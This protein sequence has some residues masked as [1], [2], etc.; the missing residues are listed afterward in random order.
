[1]PASSFA[2]TWKLYVW[3]GASVTS[4]F[5]AV[6]GCPTST[7]GCASTDSW[8]SDVTAVLTSSR[9]VH[10]IATLS[11]LEGCASGTFDGA[12]KRWE[13]PKT[14]GGTLSMAQL[15]PAPIGSTLPARSTAQTLNSCQPWL[16]P[17]NVADVSVVA[18]R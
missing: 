17:V 8:S 13:S 6:V 11:G 16:R 2:R 5:V 14:V 9:H 4:A 7:K 12:G 10:T 15:L 1:M 18:T 3:P